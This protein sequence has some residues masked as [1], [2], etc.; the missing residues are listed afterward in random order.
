MTLPEVKIDTVSNFVN[1]Q[2]TGDRMKD[3]E[4]YTNMYNQQPMFKHLINI[5]IFKTDWSEERIEGYCRG[6]LQAWHLLN[7]QY[8]IQ[9]LNEDE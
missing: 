4:L 5:A 3:V 8:V 7:E 9:E 6:M 2:K 1:S